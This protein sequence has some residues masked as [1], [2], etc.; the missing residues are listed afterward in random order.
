MENNELIKQA[1]AKAANADPN[2][3]SAILNALAD[4]GEAEDAIIEVYAA[5][6]PDARKDFISYW[7]GLYGKEYATDMAKDYVNTGKKKKAENIHNTLKKEALSPSGSDA[8]KP[9]KQYW[10]PLYGKEYASDMVKYPN[11]DAETIEVVAGMSD[12]LKKFLA[13]AEPNIAAELLD[14]ISGSS[15]KK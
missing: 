6:Q 9:V 13:T 8:N 2:K 11:V 3:V 5:L 14:I 15:K 4:A 10:T 7:K 1:I 12:G